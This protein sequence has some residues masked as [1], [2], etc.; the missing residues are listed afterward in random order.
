MDHEFP[1]S[2][3]ASRL[4]ERVPPI[5]RSRGYRLYDEKGKRYLD[6][7]L[8]SGR[9]MMGRYPKKFASSLKAQIDRGGLASLPSVWTKR[10]EKALCGLFPDYR[11]FRVYFGLERALSVLASLGLGRPR[12]PVR[13]AS[14]VAN[15]LSALWRPFVP[16]PLPEEAIV[17]ILPF[18]F[19]PAP[20]PVLFKKREDAP[21]SDPIAPFW[22]AALVRTASDFKRFSGV[23]TESLW[24]AFDT[25]SGDAWTRRGPWLY[26]RTEA[27]KYPDFFDQCL[28][29]GLLV[30]PDPDFPSLVPG[31][32]SEGDLKGLERTH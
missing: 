27:D 7:F 29:A 20:Q 24:A 14:S 31:E 26:P 18:P 8:D 28:S 23:Y 3:A 21:P 13:H 10:L 17:P 11:I 12:D 2:S 15:S 16:D 9:A 25:L 22:S 5:S 19:V 32:Y 6:L 1:E 30:S 4:L